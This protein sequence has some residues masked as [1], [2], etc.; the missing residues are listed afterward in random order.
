MNPDDVLPLRDIHLPDPVSWWPPAIGWWLLLLLI[1]LSLL[2]IYWLVKKI[3]KPVLKKSAKEELDAVIS[4]YEIHQNKQQVVKEL[5]IAIRR[6]GISY[7]PR[8]STAGIVGA[9]WYA[10]LNQLANKDCLR[11]DVIQLLSVAPYQKSPEISDKQLRAVFRQTRKW[12]GALSRE[13]A[14]V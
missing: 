14:D 9:Q 11:T 13:K 7:L 3:S 1:L 6:I 12:L 2:A 5:S 10:R 4:A 8:N